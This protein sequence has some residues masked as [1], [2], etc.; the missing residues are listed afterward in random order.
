ML[1]IDALDHTQGSGN[2]EVTL[3]EYGDFECPYCE[4][5]FTIVKRLQKDFGQSLKFV[6]RHFPLRPLHP[7][8]SSPPRRPSGRRARNVLGDAR[9]AL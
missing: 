2:A 5:A 9:D 1:E 7:T 8:R 4:I 3:V 6:Y